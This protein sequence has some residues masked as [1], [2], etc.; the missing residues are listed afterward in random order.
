M[1]SKR[2]PAPGFH[3]NP[4]HRIEIQPASDHWQ[5]TV[6]GVILADS[7]SAL[8]LTE[9]SYAKVIY[10]PVADVRQ[11]RLVSSQSETSC[12]FKG[13]ANYFRLATA[14]ETADIAWTY[15]S[16]Y[17]EVAAIEGYIAFYA[18]RIAVNPI[19]TDSNEEKTSV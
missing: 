12:P 8:E 18:D 7:N 3:R 19:S 5:A 13:R 4:N 10:F 17:N 6:D 11:E 14:E 16:T 9:G 1:S 15:P 2:G